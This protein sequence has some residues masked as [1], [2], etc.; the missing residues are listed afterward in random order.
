[1]TS[2]LPG[3]LVIER[4]E[5]IMLSLGED[6]SDWLSEINATDPEAQAPAENSPLLEHLPDRDI[7]SDVHGSP[8][9]SKFLKL[10]DS[11][12][13]AYHNAYQGF[14]NSEQT[15]EYV[16]YIKKICHFSTGE[17]LSEKQA[18]DV[19]DCGDSLITHLL[20]ESSI[21]VSKSIKVNHRLPQ[22]LDDG[23]NDLNWSMSACVAYLKYLNS[24]NH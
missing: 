5:S 17:T 10:H 3:I 19:K 22:L 9:A 2:L 8:G 13:E 4:I 24:A 6:I 18:Q 12:Q 21:A 16:G 15:D 14:E 1:L 20:S 23:T 11:E 7:A